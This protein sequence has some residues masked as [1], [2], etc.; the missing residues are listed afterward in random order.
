MED[1]AAWLY[2]LMA[3]VFKGRRT[4]DQTKEYVIAHFNE[5]RKGIQDT[6]E[7]EKRAELFSSIWTVCL[8]KICESPWS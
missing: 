2:Q 5:I 7:P 4:A 3:S 8:R 6:I 1:Y